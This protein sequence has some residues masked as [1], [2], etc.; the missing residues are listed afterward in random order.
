MTIRV[1]LG[2]QDDE[3]DAYAA[4]HKLDWLVWL[5]RIDPDCPHTAAALTKLSEDFPELRMERDF[6]L[7]APRSAVKSVERES[8]W[9]ADE[10][11]ARPAKEWLPQLLEFKS[12]EPFGPSEARLR[13]QLKE[14]AAERFD[15]GIELADALAEGRHWDAALWNP[16]LEVWQLEIE[17]EDYRQALSR[18]RHADLQR[19]HPEAACRVL[20]KLVSGG[21]R[22]FARQMLGAASDL[23]SSLW[24]HVRDDTSASESLDWFTLSI[25]RAAGPLAEFW[26]GSLSVALREGLIV[27][28]QLEEPY[29]S[30]LDEIVRDQTPA[31]RM[32][33]AFLMSGFAFLLNVDES[34]TRERLTPLLS[35]PPSTDEFQAAWDGLMYGSLDVSS[36]DTLQDPFLSAAS[37]VSTFKH[38]H[39]RERF[40]DHL[41]SLLIDFVDDPIGEWIPSFIG[42]AGDHDRGHF[43]WALWRRLSEMSEED[44]QQL[45]RHW[46]RRYW[47]NRLKGVPTPLMGAEIEWMQNWLLHLDSVFVEGVDL[48]V[49]M[50]IT[51]S[52]AFFLIDDLRAGDQPKREPNAVADL[53]IRLAESESSLAR[54]WEWGPLI[55]ELL[56]SDLTPGRSGSLQELRIR[57]G[58]S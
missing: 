19:H 31:G 22:P 2:T 56:Q 7:D 36:V 25:N 55:E 45:W 20:A 1:R 48:A 46:L 11:L 6:D 21:G 44:T 38:S 26:L 10:L 18:L 41:V 27:R 47:V 39:T 16:V 58:L 15:W 12:D 40:V 17:E 52:D 54:H 42:N 5:Q 32:A 14:A 9:T 34:W 29:R 3:M 43:A 28:G 53:L 23:A 35:E 57:L 4:Q 30:A 51:G 8:P 13:E 33:R 49:Q 37:Y 50:P 24:A